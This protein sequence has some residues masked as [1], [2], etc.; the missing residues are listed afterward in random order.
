M[1]WD[2]LK[3]S[4]FASVITGGTPSTVKKEYWEN[5]NI[6]WLNSGELNQE[7]IVSCEN[8][9]TDQ[10]LQN[11]AARLMPKDSV[12][13]ALT[14]ATTGKVGYLTFPASANQSVTGILPSERHHPKYLYYFL[15]S[16]REKVLQ[17]SYGGA[18]K[19]ISQGYVK[20]LEIPLPPISTQKRIT[21]ILDTADA[22]RRKDQD[23]R[24]KYDDLAQA[25]FIDMFGDPVKNDKG[26]EV[27]RIGDITDVSSGGTPSRLIPEY[28]NGEIP[29]VKT[30]EVNGEIIYKTEEYISESGLKNSSCKLFPKNS[31]IIAMYGQGKTRGQ[32]GILGIE[33]TTNQACGVILPCKEVNTLY[34]FNFLLLSYEELRKLGR[35]GNQE[36]LNGGMIKD[37][38]I[39][40]PPRNIQNEFE[41]Q[42]LNLRKQNHLQQSSPSD[43]LF[44]SLLKKAFNGELIT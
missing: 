11:S 21:E 7:I 43:Q 14:G 3:V 25:I 44:Q 15:G 19:H 33:A 2:Y 37:F 39:M 23:L 22:L 32:V 40:L 24:R 5:G 18:Q 27:R 38:E 28:Y 41:K 29:W 17:D 1:S 31:I 42:I 9:I 12:L 36:N 20:E 16:I 34:L 8:R 26:W 13:I 6:P 35:G 4:D 10:G 30:T